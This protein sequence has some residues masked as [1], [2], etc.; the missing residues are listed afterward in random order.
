MNSAAVEI[1]TDIDTTTE[2]QQVLQLAR[3]LDAIGRRT[4]EFL[5][6]QLGQLERAIDEFEAEKAA[7]RRQHRR[8]SQELA[9]QREEIDRLMKSQGTGSPACENSSAPTMRMKKVTA[10]TDAR[11]SGVDPL[12]L[13]I[14]TGRATAMQVSLLMFEISKLNRDMGGRGLRFETDDVRI[15]RKGL[16][17]LFAGSDACEQIVELAVFPNVPLE[18][19]GTHVAFDVDLTDQ[20]EDW[21]TFKSYLLQTSLVNAGL[22]ETF[23]NGKSVKGQQQL[24][25]AVRDAVRSAETKRSLP[26][27][28]P[29]SQSTAFWA[30]SSIDAIEQQVARVNNCYERL[31]QEHGLLMHIEI[32]PQPA[33][34]LNKNAAHD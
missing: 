16:L 34:R 32:Y 18:P 11:F 9:R 26:S 5:C 1:D 10:E 30:L 17:G 4:E 19:R 7:W 15:P 21:I 3:S 29:D 2:H 27:Q 25:G 23:R 14:Q 20:L 28:L 31:S 8:E 24:C 13:L 33:D 22:V 12:R 6:E